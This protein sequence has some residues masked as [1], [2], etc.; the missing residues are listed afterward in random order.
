MGWYKKKWINNNNKNKKTKK[1][2]IKKKNICIYF[3]FRGGGG[4]ALC[5]SP[6]DQKIF[7]LLLLFSC[8]VVVVDNSLYGRT[9]E[10]YR[11]RVYTP[12]PPLSTQMMYCTGTFGDPKNNDKKVVIYVPFGNNNNI[13]MK[14]SFLCQ[15]DNGLCC[16]SHHRGASAWIYFRTLTLLKFTNKSM[17]IKKA[18]LLL[19]WNKREY[20]ISHLLF[21]LSQV[22]RIFLCQFW[23]DGLNR[24]INGFEIV[25]IYFFFRFS[26]YNCTLNLLMS[27]RIFID[28]TSIL[29]VPLV[30]AI[31]K[32]PKIKNKKKI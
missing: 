5:V 7:S 28:C 21:E 25:E 13:H 19:V 2:K 26:S 11:R 27:P 18:W 15:D 3:F 4:V 29:Q 20:S 24:S 30:F 31:V 17:T 14:Q 12:S 9:K 1:F 23:S 10:S 16:C 32:T 22:M 6:T 8:L